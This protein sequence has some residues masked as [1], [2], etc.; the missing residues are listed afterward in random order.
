MRELDFGQQKYSVKRVYEISNAEGSAEMVVAASGTASSKGEYEGRLWRIVWE[1]S[2]FTSRKTTPFGK[3][4]IDLRA[5]SGQ[6]VQLWG[7]KLGAGKVAEACLDLYAPSDRPRLRAIYQAR[8]VLLNT[9]VAGTVVSTFPSA[10][11]QYDVRLRAD[12]QYRTSV[13]GLSQD[14]K[15]ECRRVLAEFYT[16]P[17]ASFGS[18]LHD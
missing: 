6:F 13:E 11:E 3:H 1:D 7:E 17:P 10:G 15:I 14:L 2:G 18:K 12:R 9:L 5:K 4:M 8:L 16:T